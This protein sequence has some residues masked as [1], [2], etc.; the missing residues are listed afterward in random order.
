MMTNDVKIDYNITISVRMMINEIN[1]DERKQ[2]TP[3]RWPSNLWFH[4]PQVSETLC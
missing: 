1:I 2:A 4:S 3:T